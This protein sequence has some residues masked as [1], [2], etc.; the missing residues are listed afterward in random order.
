MVAAATGLAVTA[1]SC[2]DQRAPVA[3][4]GVGD[5]VIDVPGKYVAP[6]APQQSPDPSVLRVLTMREALA[7]DALTARIM[8]GTLDD[9]GAREAGVVTYIDNMLAYREGVPEPFYREQPWAAVYTGA[10]PPQNGATTFQV[11]WIAADQID[12]YG[13]QSPL[14]PREVYRLGLAAVERYANEQ[15]GGDLYFCRQHEHEG[16]VGTITVTE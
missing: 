7:L 8:P 10:A 14:S 16:M 9:P 11:I 6:V 15:F 4:H 1:T 3:G 12:R 13:V 5:H 2:G